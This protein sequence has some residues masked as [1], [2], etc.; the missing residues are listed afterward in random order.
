VCHARGCQRAQR[1]SHEDASGRFRIVLNGI[2]ENHLELRRRLAADSI[3]L[4][5]DTD[6][7]VVAHLIA[8]DWAT[9][10]SDPRLTLRQAHLDAR[11][12]SR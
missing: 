2:I 9:P 8:P 3:A 10:R 4:S 12:T 1:P 5:S 7:E 6:A 11:I